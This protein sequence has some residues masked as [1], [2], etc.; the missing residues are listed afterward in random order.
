[1]AGLS[2]W[3]HTS[4]RDLKN[5]PRTS[6]TDVGLIQCF[7]T[8]EQC[9]SWV[10]Y[11][12]RLR[13]IFKA[14]QIHKVPTWASEINS[15]LHRQLRTPHNTRVQ[16]F[17]IAGRKTTFKISRKYSSTTLN[18]FKFNKEFSKN[19]LKR[20]SGTCGGWAFP[21]AQYHYDCYVPILLPK[22]RWYWAKEA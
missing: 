16:S 22:H 5:N 14:N 20:P 21:V 13:Q 9:N 12:G 18:L 8:N 17:C 11:W 4:Q 15:P 6:P 7:S 19:S 2:D 10:W 3:L 1:M